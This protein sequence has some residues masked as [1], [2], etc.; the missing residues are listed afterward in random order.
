MAAS[1]I[2]IQTAHPSPSSLCHAIT[3]RA[4]PFPP[5][6]AV[7]RPGASSVRP[8]TNQQAMFRNLCPDGLMLAG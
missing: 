4:L 2:R 6:W 7:G 3:Q 8:G 5:R 1:Y